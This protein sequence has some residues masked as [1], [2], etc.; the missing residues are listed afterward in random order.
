[1]R[2][3]L[4]S[5]NYAPEPT[6]IA[7]VSAAWATA[8]RD[9]GHEVT[10]TAAHP[11]Y[12]EARWG[13]RFRPYRE[14]IEGIDVMR[15]P[16]WIG[17]DTT[18]QRIRQEVTWAA[19]QS[20]ALAAA[21]RSDVAVVV[22]PSF[23]ALAPTIFAMRARRI[24]WVLWLQDILPDGAATTGM[25]DDGGGLK[26]ARWLEIKAYA[27]TDHIVVISDAFEENLREKGVPAEKITRIYNPCSSPIVERERDFS[28]DPPRILSIGNIGHSQGLDDVVRAFQLSDPL[29][30]LEA[31][32]VITGVGTAEEEVRSVVTSDRV[33]MPGLLSDEALHAEFDRSTL[34]LVSQRPGVVE[35]NMPSK[36]MNYMAQGLPVLAL[37]RP[38]SEL[39]RVVEESGAGWTLDNSRLDLLGT[40]LEKILS[41]R[42]ELRRRAD[43]SRE[44]ARENFTPLAVAQGFEQILD[45]TS[46]APEPNS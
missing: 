40:T 7:P 38:G 8:M 10:V 2:I 25:I 16:L 9:L 12:P 42:D 31:R 34:A 3:H 15:W 4:W 1:M 37:A 28:R 19:S 18:A 32:L 17:R 35:F 13:R 46:K 11:H 26:A 5:Y 22:S 29:A 6:G 20:M 30:A 36:L 27:A 43:A 24:P 41:N 44:Y 45:T 14:T 39:E 33:E 23:P 21:P